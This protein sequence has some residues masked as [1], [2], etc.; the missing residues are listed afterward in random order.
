MAIVIE[1]RKTKSGFITVVLWLVILGVIIGAAYYLFFSQP[2]LI[3][4]VVPSNLQNAQ[5]ITKISVNPQIV[6]PLLQNLKVYIQSGTVPTNLG[7]S[8]P[9]LSY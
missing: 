2:Q 8:N 9:F 1:E 4:V 6:V 5:A 3:E 7:R